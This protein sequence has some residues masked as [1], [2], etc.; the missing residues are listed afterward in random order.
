MYFWMLSIL[1]RCSIYTLGMHISMQCYIQPHNIYHT[2]YTFYSR[3]VQLVLEPRVVRQES[4]WSDILP[5]LFLSNISSIGKTFNLSHYVTHFGFILNELDKST[6]KEVNGW[7]ED[8]CPRAHFADSFPAHSNWMEN[9]FCCTK[10]WQCH[11]MTFVMLCAKF[12]SDHIILIWVRA[13]LN[14]PPVWITPENPANEMGPRPESRCQVDT[15]DTLDK[16]LFYLF[17]CRGRHKHLRNW[18]EWKAPV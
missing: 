17:L 4:V 3:H 14:Y 7:G 5:V 2:F 12:C 10:F 16:F 6:M 13:K 1:L 9:R 15:L 11:D 18:S 8:P